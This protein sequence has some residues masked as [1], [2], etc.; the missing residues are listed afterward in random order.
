MLEINNTLLVVIDVQGKL[1]QSMHEKASLFEDIAKLI[2]AAGVLE[3][4]I[5]R[6]EQYP[7]G[8]GATI[9]E[10]AELLPG[11]AISKIAFS[12]CGERRFAEAME[13]SGRNQVLLCGIETHVCVYQTAIDLLE[14]GH[15]VHVVADAVSSRTAANK[16]IGLAKMKDAGAAVTSVETALF[17]LLKEAEG[18]KFKAI[19]RIVK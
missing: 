2:K 3:V 17:E 14:S 5:I 15:E 7:E 18:E 9:P 12:C 10:I 11:E 8:L 13:K 1:A 4:P 16:A 6:T 19:L